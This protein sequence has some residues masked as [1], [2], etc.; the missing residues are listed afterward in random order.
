MIEVLN[1]RGYEPFDDDG[2]I[3]LRN[4]PFDTLAAEHRDLV[5]TMNLDVLDGT[6]RAL[7]ADLDVALDPAPGR[8]CVALRPAG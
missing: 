3:R 5:C 7:G 2:T 6:V 4:C 1:E 8:C